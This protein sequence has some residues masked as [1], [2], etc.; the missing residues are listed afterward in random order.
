LKY[1]SA[2]RFPKEEKRKYTRINVLERALTLIAQTPSLIWL[3]LL[4]VE[5][6]AH[7]SGKQA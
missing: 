6:F 7:H 1:I 4:P 2:N 3:G 5:L